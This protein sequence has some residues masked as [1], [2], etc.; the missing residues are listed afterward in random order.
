MANHTDL[1]TEQDQRRIDERDLAEGTASRCDVDG[2]DAIRHGSFSMELHLVN[3]HDYF[4]D[5]D[6]IEAR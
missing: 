3:A 6:D 1:L 5:V 4:P 2:C